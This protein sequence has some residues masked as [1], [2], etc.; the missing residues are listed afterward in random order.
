ML[1][2]VPAETGLNRTHALPK[3]TKPTTKAQKQLWGTCKDFESFMTGM[4]FKQ[5]HESAVG[6]SDPLNQGPGSDIFRGMLDDE[7]A[8][9]MSATSGLGLAE[10]MY[11]QLQN[12]V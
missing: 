2:P 11:R 5:M 9:K 10:S 3:D 7:F 12:S 8:K 4:V 6:E 1:G